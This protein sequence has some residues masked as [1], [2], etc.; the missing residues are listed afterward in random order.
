MNRL[1][2]QP[3]AARLRHASLAALS[4]AGLASVCLPV[5]AVEHPI[6]FGDPIVMSAQGQRLKVL[7]PFETQMG[8]RAT[9]VAFMVEKAEVP[10][11]HL[12]PRA[13]QF[14]VMRPDSSPYVI[15]HS[16][17][18][19]DAPNIMLTISVAGDPNSP[20]QM[21]VNVPGAGSTGRAMTLQASNGHRDARRAAINGNSFRRVPKARVMDDLPPK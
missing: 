12:A 20:Y 15:F 14:T 7:L 18:T 5:S 16:A 17:E 6:T 9:A 3:L 8:D 13:A 10:D 4:A 1:Q 11:G 2:K 21:R 19:L